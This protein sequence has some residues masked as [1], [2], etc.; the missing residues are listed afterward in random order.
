M[1]YKL[2]YHNNFDFLRIVFTIFVILHHILNQ[3]H[4]V[5]FAG[6]SVDL[7]FILSGF[8]L[9][10]TCSAQRNSETFIVKKIVRFWPLVCFATLCTAFLDTD[11]TFEKFLAP[12]FFLPATGLFGE[13]TNGIA[14]I[15]Y[16]CVLFWVSIFY[17][18]IIKNFKIEF[19]NAC[20]GILTFYNYVVCVKY[21]W[22][23]YETVDFCR[24]FTIGM[25]R[26]FAGIGCGY[27]IAS[28]YQNHINWFAGRKKISLLNS[29]CEIMIFLYILIAMFTLDLSNNP[30][31]M[32]ISFICLILL[33]LM[34]K[35]VISYY[36]EKNSLKFLSDYCL[37]IFLTHNVIFFILPQYIA[38]IN[39]IIIQIVILLASSIIFGIISHHLIE[40][41]SQKYLS[42]I[43]N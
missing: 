11:I 35:G 25:A 33:F 16:I 8:F 2:H 7:F 5:N 43:I 32:V 19:V 39:N 6:T 10:Y 27:F 13:F 20:I 15:W 38:D 42:N 31:F 34:K 17:F 30:I 12:L 36:F 4:Y 1:N 18:Y 22:R 26:G 28:F 21:G 9:T 40:K 23:I 29:I 14:S 24:I 37:S 41:P 3:Y